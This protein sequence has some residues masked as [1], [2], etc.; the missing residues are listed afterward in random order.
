M[1]AKALS[2]EA[3]DLVGLIINDPIESEKHARFVHRPL[4]DRRN[5]FYSEAFLGYANFTALYLRDLWDK[6]PHI[7]KFL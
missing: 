1:G 3:Y 4:R 5:L 6:H 7:S 2:E